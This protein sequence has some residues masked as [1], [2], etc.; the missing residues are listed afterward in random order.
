MKVPFYNFP[1]DTHLKRMYAHYRIP[2][3]WWSVSCL[4]R[5][6][7]QTQEYDGKLFLDTIGTEDIEDAFLLDDQGNYIVSLKDLSRISD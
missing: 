4:T 1:A 3:D 7:K 2:A 5:K 6:H